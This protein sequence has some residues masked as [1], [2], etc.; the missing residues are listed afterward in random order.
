MPN[1]VRWRE[2]GATYFFTV[3]T[4][5]RRPLFTEARARNALRRALVEVRRSQP[6]EMLAAVLLPDHLHCIWQL[7]DG[8]SEFSLRWANIKRQTTQLYL[9]AGGREW[10]VNQSQAAREE[11]GVWQ[12]R[13]WEHRIRNE[14]EMWA[15]RD[16]IHLNPVKHGYAADPSAWAWSSVH[17]H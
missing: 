5:H 12:A 4:Y 11:R 16:Y 8:D 10:K 6:F 13:F 2:T 9:S 1:Y 7:P 14:Q 3:V 15:Y 17:R